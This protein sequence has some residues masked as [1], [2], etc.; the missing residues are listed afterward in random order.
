MK[1]GILGYKGRIHYHCAPCIDAWL[2]TLSPDIPKTEVFDVI[3]AHI[4]KE[5]HRHYRIFPINRVAAGAE[6]TAEEQADFDKYIDT[7]LKKVQLPNPDW[8]FL[9]QSIINMYANPYHNY[10]QASR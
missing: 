5:I 1:T 2:D 7:Q 9:R 4:D 10:V 3:A 8:D 6:H